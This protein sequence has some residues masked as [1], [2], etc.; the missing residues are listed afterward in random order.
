[1][2]Q[3]AFDIFKQTVEKRGLIPAG[4]K[5]LAA[6]SGGADSVCMLLML[7]RLM[8]EGALAAAHF[9]HRLRGAESDRDEAFTRELCAR[10]GIR[11]Y[12]GTAPVGV[13]AAF[14]NF[15]VEECARKYRYRFLNAAAAQGGYDVIAV[16]HNSGDN[17]ETILMHILRGGALDGLCG[18]SYRRDNIIRPLLDVSRPQ[19]ESYLKAAGAS[20]IQDSTNTDE[21]LLRNRVR[22]TILPFLSEQLGHDAAPV[23]LRQAELARAERDYLEA[24]AA[25]FIEKAVRTEDG[26]LILDTEKFAGLPAAVARRVVR[27][28][29]AVVKDIDG[30]MPY[31]GRKDIEQAAVERVIDLIAKGRKGSR[32]VCGRGVTVRLSHSGAVFRVE[33]P[34]RN[35]AAA[36]TA[37]RHGKG[38]TVRTLSAAEFRERLSSNGFKA[39]KTAVFFDKTKY[40]SIINRYGNIAPVLRQVRPGDRIRPFGMR[41]EKTVQKLLIDRK[42]PQEQR[43]ELAVLALD[44]EVLW[45]PGVCSGELTRIDD[46]T[47]EAIELRLDTDGPLS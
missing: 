34:G 20:Y 46:G 42:I 21:T 10:E 9:N 39:E 3:D 29:I 47:R 16:A 1:M 14:E 12:C 26:R 28:V 40:L 24:E 41:G 5:V 27:N 30:N 22:R 35:E 25:A 33:T 2:K 44:S 23:L 36:R 31:G 15:G 7:K 38:Y 6:V 43:A 17:A 18:I 32:A 8:P 37:A 45:I 11:F 4:T 19:I 13:L